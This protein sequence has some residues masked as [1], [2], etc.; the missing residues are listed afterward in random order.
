ME[1]KK[2]QKKIKSIKR[3]H[4]QLKDEV[5]RKNKQHSWQRFL[6]KGIKKS[7]QKLHGSLLRPTESIFQSPLDNE[8]KVGVGRSGPKMTNFEERTHFH[9]LKKDPKE[10]PSLPNS[11]SNANSS[12]GSALNTLNTANN[13]ALSSSIH[14]PLLQFSSGHVPINASSTVPI[15][16]FNLAAHWQSIPP[17]MP[18]IINTNLVND[19]QNQKM[20][21]LHQ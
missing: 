17:P 5:D 15:S 14:A 13:N 20:E 11:S 21:F 1:R 3:K 8:A 19:S 12:S 2:R 18:S 4:E 7:Q 6:S 16:N 9:H 10:Y